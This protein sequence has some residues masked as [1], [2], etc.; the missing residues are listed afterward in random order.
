MGFLGKIVSDLA[1]VV[2]KIAPFAMLLPPPFDVAA[3][4]AS[5]ALNVTAGLMQKPPNW[6]GIMT[7]LLMGAIPM[8]MGK[9]LEAF[10]AGGTALDFAKIFGDKLSGTLGEV[11]TKVGNP[12]FTNIIGQLQSK[13]GS[14]AFTSKFAS[15]VNTATRTQ[16]GDVL[17]A[18]Q[19]HAAAEPIAFGAQSM[20]DPI[21]SALSYP[22]NAAKSVYYDHV[23]NQATKL[24]S[25]VAGDPVVSDAPTMRVPPGYKG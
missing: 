21:T 3:T 5:M 17:T 7:N 24:P 25:P 6:T 14:E 8:G 20:L 9:A 16:P 15:I 22:M 12:Q 4:V 11:A 1:G 10:K 13:I 18:A 23:V 2:G 19:I